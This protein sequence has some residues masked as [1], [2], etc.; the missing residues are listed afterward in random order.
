MGQLAKG[1]DQRL[2]LIIISLLAVLWLQAPRLI[3]NFNVDEDFR[4]FYRMSQFA[5]PNLFPNDPLTGGGAVTVAMPWGNWPFYPNSPG[6]SLLYYVASFFVS[7][8]LFSK[9]LAFLLMPVSAWYLFELGK[10][11]RTAQTGMILALGFVF[12]NLASPTSL[13]VLPGLQ[14]SFALTLEIIL[15]YYLYRQKYVPAAV[16]VVIAALIYAPA[17]VLAAA[18]WG[19]NILKFG[20]QHRRGFSID[21]TSLG[22]LLIAGFLGALIL[23][24]ALLIRFSP[25]PTETATTGTIQQTTDAPAESYRFLW[26]DPKY[27]AGGRTQL[28]YSFPFIGRGGLVNKDAD[29]LHLSVLFVISCLIYLVQG[30]RAFDLPS[31]IWSVFGASLITFVMAWLAIWLTNSFLLYLPSRYTRVGLFLFLLLV[32]FL[33]FTDFIKESALLIRRNQKRLVWLI[34]G[35]EIVA[36]GLIV[37]YPSE[38]AVFMGLNMKWLLAPTALIFG[39]LGTISIQSRLT[40]DPMPAEFNRTLSGRVLT[41][42]F[43][44]ILLSGWLAYA[45]LISS[46]SYLNPDP[47]ERELLRFLETLPQDTLIAGTP[48]ALDSVLLFSKRQILFSCEKISQDT[49]LVREALKVYYTD[50]TQDVANFCQKRGVDYLVI[51]LQTYSEAFLA[52]GE[53]FFEPYN[54]ELLP[55]IKE[56]KT[57]ALANLPDEVKIFQAGDYFVVPCDALDAG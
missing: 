35:I 9:L 26:D 40:S 53:I 29:A 13:S 11:I 23:I 19:L 12:L 24:P 43:L 7:P 17:F 2:I 3:D 28:F 42:I 15:I 51:D 4:S 34:I 32:V 30:R 21:T 37:I 31:P 18:I 33:N 16:V 14:R 46:G 6:Y 38:Q 44:G 41:I 39:I 49:Q 8:I 55:Y 45:P 52:G 54:Q 57:F 10:S 25:Y 1:F 20:H 47:T 50:D 56:R 22:P 36:I 48:C 5:D 27:Q